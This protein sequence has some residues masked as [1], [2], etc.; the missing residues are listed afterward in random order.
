MKKESVKKY[1]LFA[2]S[3]IVG[4]FAGWQMVSI[5]SRIEIPSQFTSLPV[6]I[7]IILVLLTYFVAVA[8]HEF[9]HAY[10]FTK[11]GIKMR[12]VVVMWLFF[13]KEKNRWVVKFRPNNLTV[14]GGV[15]IPDVGPVKSEQEID[16]KQQALAKALI[17]GPYSSIILWLGTTIIALPV[18]LISNN[19]ILTST[20]FTITISLTL[21][22]LILLFNI[23]FKNEVAVGDFPAYKLAKTNRFFVEM[24]LYQYALYSTDHEQV[25]EENEYLRSVV[26]KSLQEKVKA[27]KT[28]IFTLGP[29]DM[30]LIEHLSGRIKELPVEIV[31]YIHFLTDSRENLAKLKSNDLLLPIYFHVVYYLYGQDETR[32]VALSLYEEVKEEIKP[33]TPLRKYLFKQAEHL[34]GIADHKEYLLNKENICTSAAHGLLKNFDGF[35][36]DELLINGTEKPRPL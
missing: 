34:L 9:G 30:L 10:S 16:E 4:A 24:Q 33:K 21:I 32:E 36:V 22:T 35:Y 5:G 31:D 17:A 28:D 15:A 2:V 20:L 23:L 14:I 3:M 25:R 8:F 6:Y 11:N 27:R 13:M 29:L 19:A 18:M 26:M 7:N 1:S 12:A